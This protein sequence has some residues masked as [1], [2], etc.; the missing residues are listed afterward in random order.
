M[1]KRLRLKTKNVDK[2]RIAFLETLQ[3]FD[4]SGM[5]HGELTTGLWEAISMDVMIRLVKNGWELTSPSGIPVTVEILE[6]TAKF[7]SSDYIRGVRP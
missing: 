3:S 7:D 2:A 1:G 5:K 4:G 6:N